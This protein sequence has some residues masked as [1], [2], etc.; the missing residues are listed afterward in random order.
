[1]VTSSNLFFKVFFAHIFIGYKIA[2]ERFRY[3]F[4]LYWILILILKVTLTATEYDVCMSKL[5]TR[6]NA[7]KCTDTKQLS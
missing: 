3:A 6:K 4:K 7:D 2:D 5:H 1:M